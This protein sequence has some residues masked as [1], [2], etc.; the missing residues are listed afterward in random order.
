MIKSDLPSPPVLSLQQKLDR[1][2]RER[3]ILALQRDLAQ[4]GLREGDLVLA[5][6]GGGR[7]RVLIARDESPPRLR[8]L[9]DDGSFSEYS[10]A[11][12]RRA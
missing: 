5:V 2:A 11:L 4:R 8:V 6:D 9:R 12:W 10:P 7:G 3:D 1:I